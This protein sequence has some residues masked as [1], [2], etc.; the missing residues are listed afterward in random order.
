MTFQSIPDI[1]TLQKLETGPP[2]PTSRGWNQPLGCSTTGIWRQRPRKTDGWN[3]QPVTWLQRLVPLKGICDINESPWLPK[4]TVGAELKAS[5]HAQGLQQGRW[6]RDDPMKQVQGA[7]AT[8]LTLAGCTHLKRTEGAQ[9]SPWR[10]GL[11]D[12]GG[13]PVGFLVDTGPG[14]VL[15]T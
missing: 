2:M 3:Q 7:T 11:P 9:E 5:H 6:N 13:N 10:S 12:H 8:W 1:R 14:S 15:N 4:T